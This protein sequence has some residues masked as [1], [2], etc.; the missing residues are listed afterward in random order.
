ME[1]QKVEAPQ[2]TVVAPSEKVPVGMIIL[3]VWLGWSALSSL[4]AARGPQLF[5]P[6]ML[7]GLGSLLQSLV[8]G[9]LATAAV[10]GIYYKKIWTWKYIIGY[11]ILKFFL[12]LTSVTFMFLDK[13]DKYI[14]FVMEAQKARMNT[15]LTVTMDTMIPFMK[16]M[17]LAAIVFAAV[18]GLIVCIY[19][20]KKRKF[21]AKA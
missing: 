5:G 18:I 8:L 17:M 19:V 11:E 1:E 2:N 21:F 13:E 3:M 14:N 6:F 15:E 16:Y 20:Y 10:Y 12:G 7:N 9:G 4:F